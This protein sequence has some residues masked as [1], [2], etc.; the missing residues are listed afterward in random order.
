MDDPREFRRG[1]LV[2]V[3]ILDAGDKNDHI[4]VPAIFFS[5]GSYRGKDGA[6]TTVF[7]EL[8]NYKRCA[9]RASQLRRR[10]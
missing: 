8:K 10:T 4:D 3:S 7:V 9:F 2:W 5:M 6:D 1:D